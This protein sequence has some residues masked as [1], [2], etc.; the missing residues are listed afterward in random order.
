MT[1]WLVPS[2]SLVIT[3]VVLR[4]TGFFPP[5][6]A[7]YRPPIT[8]TQTHSPSSPWRAE[9][10][11]RPGVRH[12]QRC[13][14]PGCGTRAATCDKRVW[15]NPEVASLNVPVCGHW[16]QRRALCRPHRCLCQP[17]MMR[18]RRV[19]VCTDRL[20]LTPLL[21]YDGHMEHALSPTPDARDAHALQLHVGDRAVLAG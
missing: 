9:S 19:C 16:R 18:W 17:Q 2:L 1:T 4:H 5:Q 8:L 15:E 13:L 11:H 3:Q 20:S 21:R 12:T 10:I 7:H 6:V 14:L